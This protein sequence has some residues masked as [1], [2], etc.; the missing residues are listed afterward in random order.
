MNNRSP[1]VIQDEEHPLPPALAALLRKA[2]QACLES[3]TVPLPCNAMLAIVDD[4]EIRR[5][6]H[7]QRQM[8]K[9]T[10]VLSFP[11]ITYAPNQT[12]RQAVEQLRAEYMPETNACFLG[13]ILIS[14][15]HVQAQAKEYGH[16]MEREFC[17]LLVHGMMH[18]M[19]YDHMNEKDKMKMR[20]MEEKAL[21]SIGMS[22]IPHEKLLE[23][24]E[25]AM[26]NAYVPY[27]HYKVG[28]CI[29]T[30]DGTMYTGCNV[31]NASYGLTNCGERTAIFKAVSEGHR[32]FQAIA[33]AGEKAPPWP[34]GACRQVMSEFCAD[35][36][37]YI[38]WDGK[39]DQSTLAELLPHSFSPSS[40]VQEV[41]GKESL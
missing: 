12:A 41:L 21:G 24:A 15:D 31:E 28:A 18:L 10:D 1:L 9:A 38:T 6:N 34:C 26:Q 37:V 5:I 17:Y 11:S 4:Q 22:R 7:T 8:D 19:G 40:G 35:I 23:Q 29:L 25:K 32:K 2:A 14:R 27:S 3:E 16:S 33:I 36:P 13:D 20:E 30:E 39:T